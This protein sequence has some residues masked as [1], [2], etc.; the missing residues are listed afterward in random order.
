MRNRFPTVSNRFPTVSVSLAGLCLFL[1]ACSSRTDVSLTGNTPSQYSHVWITTQEVWFNASATA[2]PDDD[3]WVKFALSTPT[4][5]DLVQEN[6]G[7]LGSIDTDLRLVPGT[8]SQIRVIPVD[9]T[10]ALTSSAQNV[11]ALYN[12]EADYVDS[13]GTTRQLP[14][15][16]LN[17]DKGIGIQASLKV[18]IGSVGSALSSTSTSGTATGSTFG[19][20]NGTLTGQTNGTLTGES[21][22]SPTLGSTTGTTAGTTGTSGT[23]S[24]PNNEFA[25]NVL[26]TSDLVPFTYGASATPGIMLSSHASAFDLA[27]VAAITGQL[28][29]TNLSSSTSTS[30]LPPIQATA[31]ALSADGSRWV[32]VASTPVNADGTFLIYPLP[33]TTSNA[34]YYDVVIHGPGMATIIIQSIN[35]QLVS[36]SS[37]SFTSSSSSCSSGTTN[38]TATGTTNTTTADTTGTTSTIGTTGLASN[39]SDTTGTA[40]TSASATTTTGTSINVAAVSLGT[41]YPRAATSYTANF[42]PGSAE[43]LPAGTLVGFYQTV[44]GANQVPHLIEASPIDPF[45]QVLANAQALSAGTIDYGT[46]TST[47]A[48]VTVV[49]AAPVEGQGSYTVSATAPSFAGGPLSSGYRIAAPSSS[50]TTTPVTIPTLPALSLAS[51]T[52]A[53]KISVAVSEASPLKYNQGELLVS[54]NGQLVAI[55][56]LNSVFASGTAGTVTVSNLPAETTTAVYYVSVRAWNS[57][58][59]SITLSRQWYPTPLDLRSSASASTDVTVN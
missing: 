2:G 42:A 51:G 13:S 20:T 10:M 1:G 43:S 56:S 8:Y 47:N 3:G 39:S 23:S 38:T 22:G 9:P 35:V 44:G 46:W 21:N 11:G 4:T 31:E 50:T 40:T 14:L 53:G 28:S 36:C 34:V 49:S 25:I 59:P 26:G 18:P 6:G 19:I 37:N 15:E 30:G 29:L 57:S 24:A 45:N 7:N 32:A 55:A 58:D 52:N 41:L 54:Q 5:V 27:Q 17:P 16:L 33:S 48:N 12:T